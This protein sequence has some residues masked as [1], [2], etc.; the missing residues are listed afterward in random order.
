MA[1]PTYEELIKE[2]EELSTGDS[3]SEGQRTSKEWAKHWGIG[4]NRTSELIR[5]FLELGSMQRVFVW[6]ENI[7]GQKRKTI[8]FEF[9]AKKKAKK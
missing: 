7:S 2:L 5:R 6:K 3:P 8:V 4:I 9:V 1:E